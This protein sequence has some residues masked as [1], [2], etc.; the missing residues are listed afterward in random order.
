MINSPDLQRR[1]LFYAIHRYFILTETAVMQRNMKELV[2]FEVL[3]TVVMKNTIFW[4]I[5]PCSLL[6]VN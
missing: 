2:G 4:D 1:P 3:T 5:T 6:K